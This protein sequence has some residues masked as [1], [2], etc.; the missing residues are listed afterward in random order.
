MAVGITV[1][2]T[3]VTTDFD[4]TAREVDFVTRFADNWDALRDIL[5]ISRPIK[6]APGTRLVKY[7]A[8]KKGTLAGGDVK[9]GAPIPF[10]EYQVVE[11]GYSD[12]DIKKYAKAI[13][14]EDVSKYGADIAIDK[15]DSAFLTDLQNIVLSDM[16][17]ELNAGKLVGVQKT[18][19]AALA[20]AKGAVVDKF[21]DMGKTV[22]DVVGFANIMD[23][24]AYVGEA[25]ITVQT[26][27]GIQYVKDFL[28]YSTLFLLPAKYVA[29]KK[30]IACPV[31]NLDIYYIDPS[32]SEY[33]KLNLRYTVAGETP[34]IGFAAVGNYNTA[35]GESYAIMGLKIWPEYEDGIAVVT[36]GSTASDPAVAG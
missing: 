10:T 17:T 19:Q 9:E 26:L 20:I 32:E 31:E 14:I 33:A 12:I 13:T 22:T 27:N 29:K 21:A 6:K 2:G 3:T 34:L 5:G 28:G 30:V 4:V 25:P 7:T 1:A 8:S 16:Y 15:T 18:W 11:S 36:V 24:Y 35:S 23:Y